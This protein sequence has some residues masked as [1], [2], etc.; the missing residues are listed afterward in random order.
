[1]AT[2]KLEVTQAYQEWGSHN[3]RAAL[4]LVALDRRLRT[5]GCE[6]IFFQ[7]TP[8]WE[9]IA[10]WGQAEAEKRAIERHESPELLK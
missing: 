10:L 9:H 5:L 4:S 2:P 1:M 3:N 8:Y 6:Q 7:S